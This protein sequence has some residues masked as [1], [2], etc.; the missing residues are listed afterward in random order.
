M[1]GRIRRLLA[2]FVIPAALLAA[3]VADAPVMAQDAPSG[4]LDGKTFTVSVH[5]PGKAEPDQDT[6]TFADGTFHSSGC[7][8]YGFTAAAYSTT[9]SEGNVQFSS[10]ATS[11]TEGAITW[12]GTI[13]GDAISGTF[14]WEKEGQDPISYAFEGKLNQATE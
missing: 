13:A 8:A 10:S 5:D 7:D 14:V 3:L 12:S 4:A 2:V 9:D 11:E 1:F 6:L